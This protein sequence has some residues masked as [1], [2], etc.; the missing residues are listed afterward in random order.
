MEV[1]L[2]ES[3]GSVETIQGVEGL[4][5]ACHNLGLHLARLESHEAPL[6]VRTE[7]CS[8]E[9]NRKVGREVAAG[10]AIVG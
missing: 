1:V 2:P 10:R 8:E 4:R 5:R 7:G 6:E 9:D 3:R